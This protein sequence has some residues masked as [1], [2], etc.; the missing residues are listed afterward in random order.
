MPV[1]Y[2]YAGD[3]ATGEKRMEL[4]VVPGLSLHVEPAV[5]IVPLKVAAGVDRRKEVRVTVENNTK[6]AATANI[7]LKVPAGWRVLPASQPVSLGAEGETTD[8]PLHRD[9]ARGA[10]ARAGRAE[11]GSD[12][13]PKRPT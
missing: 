4:N 2:R 10:R 8:G 9:A 6:G 13:A 11:G 1:Q 12:R 7:G 5:M 3:L